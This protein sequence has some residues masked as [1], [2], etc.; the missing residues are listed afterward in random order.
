MVKENEE[1][2]KRMSG[3]ED[4]VAN[5]IV[6][7]QAMVKVFQER[8]DHHSG[9]LER[10]R[11]ELNAARREIDHLQVNQSTIVDKCLVLRTQVESMGDNLCRSRL[12]KNFLMVLTDLIFRC[13]ER[14][15]QHKREDGLEYGDDRSQGSYH[16]PKLGEENVVPV[17]VLG[18]TFP[19]ANQS[20]PLSDQENIPPRMVT[21]LPLNILVP[22]PEEEEIRV[23]ECCQRTLAVRNQHAV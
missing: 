14:S 19:P 11:T 23:K 4:M 1:L 8:G 13:G 6:D 10:H 22:V 16:T 17:P 21:L 20:L 5:L 2:K 3:I 12:R 9:S 7:Q 18:P 15:R